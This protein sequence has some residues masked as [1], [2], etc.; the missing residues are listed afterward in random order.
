MVFRFVYFNSGERTRMHT[1]YT[2]FC[3]FHFSEYT[4]GRIQTVATVANA[5]VRFPC[6]NIFNTECGDSKNS[7]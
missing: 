2:L 3:T 1:D 5:T 7:L 6:K 4:Q